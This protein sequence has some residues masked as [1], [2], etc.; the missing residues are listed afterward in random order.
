MSSCPHGWPLEDSG[1]CPQCRAE[2]GVTNE[3]NAVRDTV[4]KPL[5]VAGVSRRPN[6]FDHIVRVHEFPV[7]SEQNMLERLFRNLNLSNSPLVQ[8]ATKAVYDKDWDEAIQ[9]L[10]QALE[11][12]LWQQTED[13]TLVG[14]SGNFLVES[15]SICLASRAMENVNR[16]LNTLNG[17]SETKYQ[18][19]R[20]VNPYQQTIHERYAVE[21]EDPSLR[22]LWSAEQD[23]SEAAKLDPSNDHFY[24]NFDEK[25]K[26]ILSRIYVRRSKMIRSGEGILMI[27]AAIIAISPVFGDSPLAIWQ[28]GIWGKISVILAYLIGFIPAIMLWSGFIGHGDLVETKTG[29][30]LLK[31]LEYVCEKRFNEKNELGKAY[32]IL[33]ITFGFT[34]FLTYITR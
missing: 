18:H 26:H 23:L 32:E 15:L 14:R 19:I 1:N 11:T 10:R 25:T 28:T 21:N 34:L 9:C 24:K 13:F 22:L 5:S 2:H 20:P 12:P 31:F 27:V 33:I 4:K 29:K 6:E 30:T 17:E 8:Q 3:T 16:A 7:L